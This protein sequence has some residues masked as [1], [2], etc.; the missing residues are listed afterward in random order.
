MD[1]G[2]MAYLKAEELEA[3]LMKSGE[4]E[5]DKPCLLRVRAVGNRVVTLLKGDGGDCAVTV[6]AR[7]KGGTGVVWLTLGGLRTDCASI[8]SDK[9]ECVLLGAGGGD[10]ALDMR[11]VVGENISAECEILLPRKPQK[12]TAQ[13]ETKLRYAVG[14]DGYVICEIKD[15]DIT[16]TKCDARYNILKT[17]KVGRGIYADVC[18]ADDGYCLIYTDMFYRLFCADLD[19]DLNVIA[20]N[21]LGDSVGEASVTCRNGRLYAFYISGG[22]TAYFSTAAR[23]G[24]RGR[25]FKPLSG[26]TAKRATAVKNADPL[27]VIVSTGGG[28]RLFKEEAEAA[29]TVALKVTAIGRM[30]SV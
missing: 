6:K 11:G 30:E 1:Y 27:A 23:N 8:A 3:K 7:I 29:K 18:R 21:A 20:F 24:S 10:I 14:K 16:L 19:G 9:T 13:S 4:R 15:G 28:N 26:I 12:Q 22:E 5:A 2:K 17:A 25:E